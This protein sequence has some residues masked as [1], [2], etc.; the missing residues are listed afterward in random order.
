[1]QLAMGGSILL[2]LTLERDK[3]LAALLDIGLQLRHLC[4]QL[5]LGGL[6][7]CGSVLCFLARPANCLLALGKLLLVAVKVGLPLHQLAFSRGLLLGSEPLLLLSFGL[8]EKEG[9]TLL[10]ESLP[11]LC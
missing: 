1:M 9:C 2:A 6:S 10:G 7:S 4:L 11:L 3:L 8:L 5:F